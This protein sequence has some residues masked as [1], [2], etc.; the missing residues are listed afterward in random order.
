MKKIDFNEKWQFSLNGS[1]ETSVDL[2]YD[3]SIIQE[4]TPDSKG[5]ASNGWYP[6]G[7]GEYKKSFILTSDQ[8]NNTYLLQ[9]EGSYGFTEVYI[10]NNL[11]VQHPHGYTEFFADLTPFIV[12]GENCVQI[13]VAND[14]M[15]NSRWYSG[16]GLYRRVWLLEGCGGY[17]HPWGVCI[18]TK[19]DKAVF[20]VSTV[21]ADSYCLSVFDGEKKI[22]SG[23]FKAE[24]KAEIII[25]DAKK[26]S[27]ESPFLYS[28]EIS[29]L[30]N[31]KITDTV[32]YK[33]GFR[34]IEINFKRGFV[35][36]GKT[37]KLLGGCVHHDNG[38]LGANAYTEAEWRKVKLLKDHGFNAV[39]TSHNPFSRDFLDA[40]DA[41]GML[42]IEEA[43]DM[44]RFKKNAYDYHLFFDKY[45]KEDAYSMIMRDRNRAS[46]VMWSDG[47]EIVERNGKSFGA[48]RAKEIA[49]YFRSLDSRPITNALCAIIVGDGN[50]EFEA[51]LQKFLSGEVTSVEQIPPHLMPLFAGLRNGGNFHEATKDFAKSL[52]VVGY[53]YMDML[54]EEMTV[55]FPER[56]A[57]TTEAFSEEMFR[58]KQNMDLYPQVIGNF[59]WTAIDY[60]GE[61]GIGRIVY[62]DETSKTGDNSGFQKSSFPYF[63]ASCGDI[64]ITG[65]VTAAGACRKV[66]YGDKNPSVWVL[67]P[68]KT[69][70]KVSRNK[71]SWIS[72]VR[73]NWTYPGSDGKTVKIEV[74]SN[75]EEVELFVNGNSVGRKKPEGLIARFETEYEQG[76]ISAVNHRNGKAAETD[77]IKTADKFESLKIEKL[78]SVCAEP[79]IDFYTITALDK[80]SIIVPTALNVEVISDG[81][82][83][84]GCDDP[85]SYKN[86]TVNNFSLY[87]GRGFAAVKKGSG[88]IVNKVFNS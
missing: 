11:V 88:I 20:D 75:A 66:L 43:F 62:S 26:W 84:C 76:S 79:D 34:D 77:E 28:A 18:T 7:N 35:L 80:D 86:F 56:I 3:F 47:N 73:R 71:W 60:L 31:D 53:N 15:P 6:G 61:A 85:Q 10:N 67:S 16:S 32:G 33:F 82:I 23:E 63:L 55:K 2:P 83:A 68:D 48:E 49:D 24:N 65:N 72:D 57:M 5:G 70:L 36:N 64:S 69:N 41:L 74:Y 46:V 51:L 1:V 21:G 44:W 54:Y 38:I 22:A 29:A 4:R 37:V 50:K 12:E 39:R 45:W 27:P 8:L 42:V 13:S 78:S 81:F 59:V 30:K 87:E 14:M 9:I 25:Q 19:G 17:I 52:D 58:D 40:C